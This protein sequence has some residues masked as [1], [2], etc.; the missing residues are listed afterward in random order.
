MNRKGTLILCAAVILVLAPACA[1]TA[2]GQ[3]DN[4][5]YARLLQRHVHDGVVD[6][7]GLKKEEQT[8]DRYL[9]LLEN[10]DS[11]ALSRPEQF[12]F[13][14]NA[15]NAWTLKLI[16][17]GYPGVK[18]IKD[19]GSLFRSPWKK[20]LC[21]L[22]GRVMTLDDIEHGI[23][24]PRFADPRV[25]FAIVCASKSCPPLKAEPYRGRTL[26]AQLDAAARAFINDPRSNRFE[27]GVL[28]LS[29]VFKWFAE[30]FGNDPAGFV[31]RYAGG[32][33]ATRL[34]SAPRPLKIAYLD[35]DWRLNG[36]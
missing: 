17:T 18:S 20:K 4:R 16:L 9:K 27:G 3:V 30:D 13:Y 31:A 19:L 21:R 11:G 24:R 22:D 36:Q 33:L 23:L 29:R 28:Y 15:Y 14:I 25:H 6:Y 26:D 35:Y 5:L 34:Q 12:A 7:R 32:Q 2:A 10:T 1:G 8:L